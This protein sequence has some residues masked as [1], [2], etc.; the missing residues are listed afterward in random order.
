MTCCALF[1]KFSFTILTFYS[2]ITALGRYWFSTSSS[3]HSHSQLLWLQ[4]PFVRSWTLSLFLYLFLLLR[5]FHHLLRINYSLLFT[6]KFG[7]FLWMD[8]LTSSL[9]FFYSI[10]IK[11]SATYFTFN[12]AV[13][14]LWFNLSSHRSCLFL[15]LLRFPLFLN[16][17]QRNWSWNSWM[18][19]FFY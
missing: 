17:L 11:E 12:S 18:N 6:I 10:I 8:F 16:I 13:C 4:F 5:L 2:V 3:L 19:L 7:P 15:E 9:M 1:C 14:R